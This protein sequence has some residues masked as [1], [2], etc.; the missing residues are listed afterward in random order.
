MAS[1]ASDIQFTCATCGEHNMETITVPETDWTGDNA[2]ERFTEDQE[3]VWCEHCNEGYSLSIQNSDGHIGITNDDGRDLK[4]SASDAYMVEPDDAA[5]DLPSDPAVNIIMTLE[6][7]R[8][9]LKGT[10]PSFHTATVL[11]MAFIQQFAALEAYLSD[12]LITEVLNKPGALQRI[13]VGDRE[14][15]E[16]K[17]PLAEIHANPGIVAHTAATHLRTL[18]YHNFKKIEVIW[19]LT[20]NFDLFPDRDMKV[21]MMKAEPIRHDCVHRNGKDKEGNIR[22]EVNDSFVRTVD[23]DIRKLIDYV[24]EHISEVG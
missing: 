13:I 22:L 17:L 5:W 23:A 6:D 11:R 21:R 18:L 2:D 1:Y 15:K 12:T 4:L 8:T 3:D 16:L 19:K 7:V 24:E 10:P 14:L 20:L 9:V